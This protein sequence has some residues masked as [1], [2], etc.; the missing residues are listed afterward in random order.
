MINVK[1]SQNVKCEMISIKKAEELYEEREYL[2]SLE[3]VLKILEKEPDNLVALE[4]KANL[5]SIKNRL[6]EAISPPTR[7]LT[8]PKVEREFEPGTSRYRLTILHR[9]KP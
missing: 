9:Q 6:P 7:N 8:P 1:K 4:M 5:C 2:G 3:L